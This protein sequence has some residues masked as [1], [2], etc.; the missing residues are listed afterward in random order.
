M[1]EPEQTKLSSG[2]PTP[3]DQR[4]KKKKKKQSKER[5]RERESDRLEIGE[6]QFDKRDDH[7]FPKDALYSL[8]KLREQKNCD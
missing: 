7:R 3:V 5:E 8:C 2:K 4:F 6:A 1:I